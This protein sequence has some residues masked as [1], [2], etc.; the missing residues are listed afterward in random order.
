LSSTTKIKFL[1]S[2]TRPFSK[3]FSQAEGVAADLSLQPIIVYSARSNTLGC[4]SG[5]RCWPSSK[6]LCTDEQILAQTT[7]EESKQTHVWNLYRPSIFSTRAN[8]AGLPVNFPPGP[9]T[10]WWQSG[11]L[12]AA[13]EPAR[14]FHVFQK[15]RQSVEDRY[16]RHGKQGQLRR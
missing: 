6:C 11:S 15:H 4:L 9:S 16:A 8:C 1:F 14:T 10:K 5:L 13:R 2:V 3:L 12:L 7:V